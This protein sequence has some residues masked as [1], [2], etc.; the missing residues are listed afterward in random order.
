MYNV[1]DVWGFKKD[2]TGWWRWQRQSLH[3]ELIDAGRQAFRQ[4]EDCIV[5][6]RR[7]GYGGSLTGSIETAGDRARPLRGSPRR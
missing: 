3:H 1:S 5:D 6:A 4:L 2:S 7:H